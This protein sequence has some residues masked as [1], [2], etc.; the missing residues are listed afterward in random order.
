MKKSIS[1]LSESELVLPPKQGAVRIKP[2]TVLWTQHDLLRAIS[3]KHIADP[4]TGV[5][6]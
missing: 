4:N 3:V 1:E 5:H 6:E 2:G